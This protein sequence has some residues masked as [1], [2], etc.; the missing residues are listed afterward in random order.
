MPAPWPACPTSHDPE[1]WIP[2]FGKDH[3][4]TIAKPRG[5]NGR[6]RSYLVATARTKPVATSTFVVVDGARLAP[7]IAPTFDHR[8]PDVP[9]VD[10]H[11]RL[12]RRLSGPD[13]DLSVDAEQS[14]YALYRPWQSKLHALA[15]RILD[16]GP[17]VRDFRADRGVLQ[18]ADRPD[19][20]APDQ[21]STGQR[22]AQ[23]ARHAAGAVGHSA[24]ALLARLVVAV[25]PHAFGVQLHP[26]ELRA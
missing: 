17:A 26:R 12:P 3:A 10:P 21:Q 24:G 18:S 13:L 1:K 22:S 6:H 20:G 14:S 4:K 23:M 11:Y 5:N 16:G 8:F 2:V 7:G 19:H 15:R 25:R 9:A